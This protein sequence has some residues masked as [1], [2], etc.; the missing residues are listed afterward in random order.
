MPDGAPGLKT[1]A[2][3]QARMGSTRL[4]GKVLEDLAGKP[5]LVR[6]VERVKRARTIEEIV[7]VTTDNS[8][9]NK[10]SELCI[11]H[12]WQ[13]FRGSEEDVLDRYYRAAM[14]YKADPVVRITSDCPLIDPA[15]IDLVVSE[16]FKLSPGVDFVS[17][18]IPVRTYPRGLDSEAI[19]FEA[20]ERAWRKDDDPVSREHVTPYIKRHPELFNLN[21]VTAESDYSEMRWTVDTSEDLD[22]VRRIYGHFGNDNFSW[23]DVL[24]LLSAHPEWLD[25][26]R[27]IRQKV[28]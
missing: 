18:D 26:N 19:K 22:F 1:V 27:H 3:I 23:R 5:M 9:D 24:R 4:P 17:N 11:S 21:G 6:V 15:V 10:I 2:I 7:I 12:S 16:F 8:V 20:L 14:A 25:I 13:C 28:V